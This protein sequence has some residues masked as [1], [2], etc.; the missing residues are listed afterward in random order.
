MAVLSTSYDVESGVKTTL[1]STISPTQ[2]TNIKLNYALAITSG[3][4]RFDP[5]TTREEFISFGGTVVSAGVTTLVDVV[6]DLTLT[7]NDFSGSGTGSQHSGGACVV[8]LSNYHALYNKKA[9]TDRANTFSAAQTISGSNKFFFS[10]A[11]QWIYSDGTELYFR[12]AS[13]S[14]KSLSQLASLAGSN[15]KAKV[16]VADTTEGFLN[17]K[18]TVSEA[19]VKSITSGGGD[20]RLN[21]ALDPLRTTNGV[22]FVTANMPA[23]AELSTAGVADVTIANKQAVAFNGNTRLG[24][25]DSNDPGMNVEWLFAG[26]AKN[27]GNAGDAIQFVPTGIVATV[28][29]FTLTQRAKCRLWAGTPTNTTQNTATDAQDASTKWRAQVFTAGALAGEDNLGA[30]TLYLTKTGAPTGNA[31]I[32]IRAVSAG[33]P[34]G[35]D[36]GTATLAYSSI[37]TGTNEFTFTVPVSITP[38]TQYAII[39]DPGA[40]VSGAA[41]ITWNYQ[42]TDVYAGGTSVTSANS[43]S[44]W[45][46]EATF[47]RYFSMKFRGIAGEPVYLSDTAGGLELTAGTYPYEIGL[48]L[49][50]TQIVLSPRMRSIYGTANLVMAAGAENV[51]TQFILGFAP[52]LIVWEA[53]L[54]SG[55][56]AFGQSNQK[57]H[58]EYGSSLA[59]VQATGPVTRYCLSTLTSN[60][61]I[62]G[63]TTSPYPPSLIASMY[64][65]NNSVYF[66]RNV[67]T[68]NSETLVLKFL[69]IA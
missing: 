58:M 45:T 13:Q 67:T 42:N 4:L 38:G 43:G 47:D 46:A 48:A 19:L 54:A 61:Q 30:V 26:I 57:S 37:A 17:T 36:L 23:V 52:S 3:V 15:D 66:N 53:T 59:T 40:G 9:N 8:E 24:L 31:T 25:A 18:I 2:T 21:L 69:A 10:N 50:T 11:N 16:S 60:G 32:R 41:Y 56:F 62:I 29:A 27:A 44:S 5:D 28:N 63:N 49:S 34:I 22:A 33:L 64:M 39:L 55:G 6:R 7:L 20:E 68:G 1:K 12:S 65:T 51:T 14:Q 35:G